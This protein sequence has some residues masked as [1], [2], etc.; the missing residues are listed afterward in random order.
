M[1]EGRIR[2]TYRSSLPQRS[3]APA[4]RAAP[5]RE[6]STAENCIYK[7]PTVAEVVARGYPASYWDKV[8]A[9]RDEL[10]RRFDA[11]PTFRA[12]AIAEAKARA[13]R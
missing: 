9:E 13:R 2:G 3:V 8:K 5:T 7:M 4:R 1:A 12:E 6:P 11:D 10:V